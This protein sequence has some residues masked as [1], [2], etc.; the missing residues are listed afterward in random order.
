M[1]GSVKLEYQVE[2]RRIDA[3]GAVAT[4]KSAEIVLDTDL[5]GRIDA[6]NPAELLLAAVAA[7]MIKGIERVMPMIAFELRGVEVKLRGVRQDS[8]PKMV[9]IDYQLIVDTDET[10]QRLELLHKNVRKYGTISNTIAEATRLDGTI[11]RKA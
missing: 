1:A 10:D 2:A 5:A 8:P 4:T 11:R 3:H 9:S 6:F 7:C